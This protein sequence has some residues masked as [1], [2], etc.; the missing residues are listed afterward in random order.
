MLKRVSHIAAA[1]VLDKLSRR[2]EATVTHTHYPHFLSFPISV[3]D[4]VDSSPVRTVSL[5]ENARHVVR[6][7][8]PRF[9]A[10]SFWKGLRS[11]R[12]SFHFSTGFACVFPLPV[13]S[14]LKRLDAR[15][16]CFAAAAGSCDVKNERKCKAWVNEKN[17]IRSLE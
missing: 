9:L 5:C 4:S 16:A 13:G 6:R 10:S 8:G 14:L 12:R 17:P 15:G 3:Q 1:R 11:F 2:V 7:V